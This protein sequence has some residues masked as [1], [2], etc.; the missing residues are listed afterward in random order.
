MVRRQLMQEYAQKSTSTT[1]PR[2]LSRVRGLE[3]SQP[4]APSSGGNGPS[5]FDGPLAPCADIIAPEF[6]TAG[7]SAA[8]I[9]ADPLMADPFMAVLAAGAPAPTRDPDTRTGFS[10]YRAGN[11]CLKLR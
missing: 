3:F 7:F 5:V 10:R 6:A 2:R 9:M 4:V 8:L 11:I 1:L